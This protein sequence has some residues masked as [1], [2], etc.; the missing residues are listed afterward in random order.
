MTYGQFL[1]G[2]RLRQVDL[3][4]PMLAMMAVHDPPAFQYLATMAAKALVKKAAARRAVTNRYKDYMMGEVKK[5]REQMRAA[6]KWDPRWND[7]E[8]LRAL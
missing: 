2:L 3:N 5:V 8:E 7:S 6:D 4:R 1:H